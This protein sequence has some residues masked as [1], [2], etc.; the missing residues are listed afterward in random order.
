MR[1]SADI[2]PGVGVVV[3]VTSEGGI[4]TQI[5]AVLLAGDGLVHG[6]HSLQDLAPDLGVQTQLGGVI[7]AVDLEVVHA[8]LGGEPRSPGHR[9]AVHGGQL[10][11][12]G[13]GR[14]HCGPGV[15]NNVRNNA[16]TKESL[17]ASKLKNGR[18]MSVFMT[19]LIWL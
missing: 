14:V 15:E 18:K 5:P 10:A 19:I 9:V 8:L 11:L 17:S 1:Q 16:E 12:S 3:A 13:L 7:D 6:I 4:L 2:V